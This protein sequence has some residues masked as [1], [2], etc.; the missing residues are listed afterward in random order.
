VLFRANS[1]HIAG[2]GNKLFTDS[3]VSLSNENSGVVNS[4]GE[5]SLGDKSLKSSLHELGKGKTQDVIELSL[6]LLE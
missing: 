1:N 4:A 6:R 3:D 2:N 5:L